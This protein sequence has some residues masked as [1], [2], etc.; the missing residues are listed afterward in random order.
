[1]HEVG[2]YMMTINKDGVHILVDIIA[3]G[4]IAERVSHVNRDVGR[5]WNG[6]NGPEH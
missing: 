5:K 2:V 6:M 1:M 4:E 3:S